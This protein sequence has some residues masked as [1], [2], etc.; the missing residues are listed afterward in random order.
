MSNKPIFFKLVLHNIDLPIT[1][2]AEIQALHND[3]YEHMTPK[4]SEPEFD[5]YI[6]DLIGELEQIRQEG[7][8]K[9]AAEKKKIRACPPYV[10]T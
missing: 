6:N 4:I 9:F 8:R 10:V 5:K 2:E 1:T 3:K 7:N